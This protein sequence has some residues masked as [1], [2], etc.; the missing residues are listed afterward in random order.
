MIVMTVNF[1]LAQ[2]A[3]FWSK[4]TLNMSLQR[5]IIAFKYN[6]NNNTEN[7][8]PI[9]ENPRNMI[10]HMFLRLLVVRLLS[11]ETSESRHLGFIQNGRHRGSPACLRQEIGS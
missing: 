5:C 2:N 8:F 1:I 7:E 9:P 11:C 4:T 10:L 3:L 6:R